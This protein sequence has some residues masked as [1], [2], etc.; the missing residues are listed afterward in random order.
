MIRK[1]KIMWYFSWLD[2]KIIR[3]KY[4]VLTLLDVIRNYYVYTRT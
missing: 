2:V 4:L 1:I 3:I